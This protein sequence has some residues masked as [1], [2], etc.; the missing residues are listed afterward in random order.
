[1]P[2]NMGL[3]AEFEYYMY[4]GTALSGKTGDGFSFFLFDGSVTTAN[5]RI[6]ANGG[7]LGY[8]QKN[9]PSAVKGVSKGYIGIGFDA[10]GNFSNP[11]DGRNGGPGVKPGAVVLRGPGDGSSMSKDN[12]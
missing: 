5:F 6:G 9:S 11:Q 4:G 10:F 8:A 1:F 2:S 7:A 3:I 12:P